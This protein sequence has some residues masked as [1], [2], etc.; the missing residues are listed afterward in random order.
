MPRPEVGAIGLQVA[1]PVHSSLPATSGE[2]SRNRRRSPSPLWQLPHGREHALDPPAS[3]LEI[4]SCCQIALARQPIGL[5]PQV[6]G[7]PEGIGDGHH[8]GPRALTGWPGHTDRHRVAPGTPPAGS[9]RS[10]TTFRN[11]SQMYRLGPRARP[12]QEWP[13][14]PFA[15]PPGNQPDPGEH[16]AHTQEVPRANPSPSRK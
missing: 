15:F 7:H 12:T 10:S 13:L 16:S 6:S 5:A 2:P 11:R 9:R 14:V 3:V 1:S 4:R 8:T